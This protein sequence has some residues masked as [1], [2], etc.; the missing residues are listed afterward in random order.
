MLA[1]KTGKLRHGCPVRATFSKRS[2]RKSLDPITRDIG[3][4]IVKIVVDQFPIGCQG[5]AGAAGPADQIYRPS[6]LHYLKPGAASST[7]K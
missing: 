2:V 3:Q 1:P 5:I 6:S 4:F 7:F